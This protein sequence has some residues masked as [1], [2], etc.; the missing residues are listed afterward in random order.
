MILTPGQL[1]FINEQDVK[2]GER[3]NYY[4][5]GIVR[6]SD[7]RDSKDR[8]LEHQTGNPR[9][10]V[11]VETLN[12]PAVEE[13][14]TS[15]HYLFARNWAMGEWMRFTDDELKKA[16]SKAKELATAMQENIKDYKRAE[17]LSSIASNGIILPTTPAAEELYQSYMNY[18][19]VVKSCDEVL[20]EYDDY[21]YA[22]IEKGIDVGG[23]ANIQNKAGTKKFDE[24]L[25]ASKYPDLYKKFSDFTYPIK[26][27]FRPKLNKD[28]VPDISTIDQEQ[29]ELIVGLKDE[30]SKADH[31]LENGFLLHDKHL[32]VLEIREYAE[33]ESSLAN[34]KLRVMTGEA[35]G[36]EGICTWKREPKETVVFDK[37]KIQ[38]EYPEEYDSCVVQGKETKALIVNPR[39]AEVK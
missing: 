24:K 33:L 37:Q 5:I 20:G 30:I 22:A 27:S 17:E 16:I 13:V 10:L 34:T 18:K 8:L 25:F 35:E 9:R 6:E 21:L 26:G 4:K 32:G 29:I 39:I 23:K 12:M 11:I 19:S 38:A 14:E 3:S 31:S 1:Y 36:I 15:L 2:T 28:W 7:E